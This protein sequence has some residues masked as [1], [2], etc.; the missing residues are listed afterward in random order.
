M[1]QTTV[2]DIRNKFRLVPVGELS[3]DDQAQL[4]EMRRQAMGA[5]FRFAELKTGLKPS[6]IVKAL[7]NEADCS[8]SAVNSWRR[9]GCGSVKVAK[10]IVRYLNS[11]SSVKWGA[12][13]IFPT[14]RELFNKPLMTEREYKKQLAAFQHS[15]FAH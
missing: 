15:R 11:L 7:A 2:N 5:V 3:K 13:Q 1:K 4:T 8:A 10:Q 6:E 9:R 14:E 12:H